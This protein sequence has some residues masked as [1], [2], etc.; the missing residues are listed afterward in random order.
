[1]RPLSTHKLTCGAAG[2]GSSEETPGAR[3]TY[4]EGRGLCKREGC[5]GMGSVVFPR[6]GDGAGR[7]IA[8]IEGLRGMASGGIASVRVPGWDMGLEKGPQGGGRSNL[9][10]K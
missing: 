3:G 8:L 7:G 4:E 6:P 1:M 9:G 5:Q 10:G 2:E